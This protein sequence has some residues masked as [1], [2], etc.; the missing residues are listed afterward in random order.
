MNVL[1]STFQTWDGRLVQH[2]LK[3]DGSNPR[4]GPGA[5][6]CVLPMSVWVLSSTLAPSHKHMDE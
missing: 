6:L 4:R 3:G 2:R 1:W 5:F